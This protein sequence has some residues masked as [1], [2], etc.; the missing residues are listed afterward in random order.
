MGECIKLPEDKRM[1]I[2]NSTLSEGS[3]LPLQAST[4]FQVISL[5]STDHTQ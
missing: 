2:K 4:I 1:Q 5:M 3:L